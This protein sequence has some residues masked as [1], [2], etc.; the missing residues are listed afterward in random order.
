MKKV[1]LVLLILTT[2]LGVTAQNRPTMKDISYT[3]EWLKVAE[4]EKKSLP[5]SASQVIDAILLKAIKEK[6]SAQVIKAS[7]HQGKYQLAIDAQNDTIIFHNLNQMLV[8]NNDLVEKSVIHSMLGELYLQYYQKEQWTINQRTELGDFVPSDMK[9]WTKNVFY[10]KVVEHLTASLS[11]KDILIETI[12]EDYAAVIEL[13]KDSRKYYPTMF[14]F[15]S[16]RAIEV[17]ASLESDE[18]ISRTLTRKGI[19]QK[20]LF[21]SA[22]EY[23][24]IDFNI[25]PSDYNLW[26]YETYRN[27]LSSSIERGNDE[28]VLLTELNLLDKLRVLKN[29]YSENIKSQLAILLQKWEDDPLSV[30]VIDKIVPQYQIEIYS[31]SESDSLLK[32]TKTKELYELLIKSISKFP[33]YSRISIL[34]NRVSSMTQPQFNI[35]GNKTFPIKADKVLT[36]SFRNIKSLNAK[37]YLINS[38]VDVQM[39]QMGVDYDI[40]D[41]RTFVKDINIPIPITVEYLFSDATFTIDV[42][43]PGTY[44]LE[45]DA[46]PKLQSYGISGNYFFTVSDLAAFARLSTK[47]KYNLFVV[48]RVTG[49]PVKNAK[50]NIYKLP[51]NW[52]DSQLTLVETLTT[53]ADGLAVYHKNIPNNDVFYNVESGNDNSIMLSRLPYAYYNMSNDQDTD[54]ESTHIFTDRS[55]YRPG[56]SVYFKAILTQSKNN[57]HLLQTQKSVEFILRDANSRE[58]TKQTLTTNEYGSVSGEFVLLRVLCQAF[59]Q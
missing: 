26:V 21:T 40:K 13:G 29:S 18:D 4:Y 2:V 27:L 23:I 44:M 53:N 1:I 6:N 57:E 43:I 9:E 52:R 8:E 7:M 28:A 30:E 37:L 48:D 10:N 49:K 14:D 3:Q 22:E 33:E 5:Q 24:K 11:H 20:S 55:L 17:F 59:S 50:V 15:L 34:E 38:P 56:Q 19:P 31:I 54:R 41:K 58:I 35:T 39:A 32:A 47:D 46:T 45:F 51:G 12:V 36:I 42:D 25:I 16:L